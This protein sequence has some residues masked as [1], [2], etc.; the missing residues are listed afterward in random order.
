M[1][2]IKPVSIIIHLVGGGV[3][4]QTAYLLSDGNNAAVVCL[5]TFVC[6]CMSWRGGE[7][8]EGASLANGPGRQ[9]MHLCR[10]QRQRRCR[11]SRKEKER[12]RG[13]QPTSTPTNPTRSSPLMPRSASGHRNGCCFLFFIL[14][15]KKGSKSC[16]LLA[17]CIVPSCPRRDFSSELKVWGRFRSVSG[18]SSASQPKKW[19][20]FDIWNQTTITPVHPLAQAEYQLWWVPENEQIQPLTLLRLPYRQSRMCSKCEYKLPW[21]RRLVEA[22]LISDLFSKARKWENTTVQLIF[23]VSIRVW[24][25]A[26]AGRCV[27]FRCVCPFKNPKRSYSYTQTITGLLDI[28]L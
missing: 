17:D 19:I 11:V 28:K 1:W 6:M 22:W 21:R 12:E 18:N 25:E 10:Q 15:L 4:W 20:K 26:T 27:V 8:K 14:A 23:V 24:I 13:K 3:R 16:L 9:V 2:E 7:E 5:C